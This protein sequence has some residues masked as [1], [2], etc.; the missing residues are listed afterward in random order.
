[1]VRKRGFVCWGRWFSTCKESVRCRIGIVVYRMMGL[2]LL[3]ADKIGAMGCW[4]GHGEAPGSLLLEIF[5]HCTQ[6]HC[7][8]IQGCRKVAVCC[9]RECMYSGYYLSYLILL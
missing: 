1:M 6:G 8:I 4:S 9:L 7:R 2:V 5:R 3:K